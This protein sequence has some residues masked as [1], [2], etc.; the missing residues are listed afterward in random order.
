MSIANVSA[1][2]LETAARIVYAATPADLK[3]M[4]KVSAYLEAARL[5]L[6]SGSEEDCIESFARACDQ[7]WHRS[8]T[9]HKAAMAM[10]G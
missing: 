4:A 7:V 8:Q 3:V 9:A 1:F 10:F 5:A 2:D 6:H